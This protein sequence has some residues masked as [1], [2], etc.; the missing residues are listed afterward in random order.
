MFSAQFKFRSNK[1]ELL[2]KILINE[3]NIPLIIQ[4]LKEF[5]WLNK[6]FGAKKTLIH[7]MEK[8]YRSKMATQCKDKDKETPNRVFKICD[9]GCGGGDLT[10]AIYKWSLKKSE[11]FSISGID[12]NPFIVE[13]AQKNIHNDSIQFYVQ[14]IFSKKII[15]SGMD[16]FCFNNVCHHFDTESLIK[17]LIHLTTAR[18]TILINDLQR[19]CISYY[20]IKIYT[21]IF[22]YSKLAKVDG[23][24]SVLKAFSKTEILDILKKANVTDFELK[25][26]WAFRWQLIIWKIAA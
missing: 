10:Q 14:D 3:S 26:R 6:I 12:I 1:T 2:D 20:F 16:V 24:L 8:I 7:G 21:Y 22:N 15:D 23:P 4:N 13:F 19:H 11:F 25:K 18:S 17:L 5:E 9:V